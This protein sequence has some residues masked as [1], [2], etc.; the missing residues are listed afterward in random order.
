MLNWFRR[1]SETTQGL[2]VSITLGALVFGL[3]LLARW[4]RG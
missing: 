1:L 2:I 3:L 4:S